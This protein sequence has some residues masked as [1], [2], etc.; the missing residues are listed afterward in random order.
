VKVAAEPLKNKAALDFLAA[1][2]AAPV[3]GGAR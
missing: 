2:P 1:H 3:R